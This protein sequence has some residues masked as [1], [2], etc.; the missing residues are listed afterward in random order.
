MKRKMSPKILDVNNI[1]FI[2]NSLY[3]WIDGGQANGSVSG[4]QMYL[5]TRCKESM[6]ERQIVMKYIGMS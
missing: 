2:S 3:L 5:K 6:R 4:I 1:R